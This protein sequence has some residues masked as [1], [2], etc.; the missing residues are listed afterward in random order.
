MLIYRNGML[1]APSTLIANIGSQAA[2]SAAALIMFV[3]MGLILLLA[4]IILTPI[5]VFTTSRALSKHAERENRLRRLLG[6]PEVPSAAPG[7]RG[8]L[9]SILTLG[10]YLPMYARSLTSAIDEHVAHT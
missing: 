5:I 1:D 8:L 3:F 10:L 4:S 7:A 2:A 6:L 9:A